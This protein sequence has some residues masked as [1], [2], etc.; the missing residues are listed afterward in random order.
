[1]QEQIQ[2]T[3]IS[4]F[5][6]IV[7]KFDIVPFSAGEKP[8]QLNVNRPGVYIFYM[9]DKV[10]KI[11]KSNKDAYVRSLQH[12]RDD[13]GGNKGNGMGRYEKDPG[14]KIVL[15]LLKDSTDVH[16]LYALECFLEM[17]YRR[18]GLVI[19]SARI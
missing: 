11:G 10:W 5:G 17:H 13:T 12:F 8:A 4:E 15:Y 14:M 6:S 18:N 2:E 16:W 19:H 1:M 7:E 9:G 3:V